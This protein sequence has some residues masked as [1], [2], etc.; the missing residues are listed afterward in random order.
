M[1]ASGPDGIPNWI[2]KDY[3]DFLA[4]PVTT[5]PNALFKEQH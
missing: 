5:I 3:S 4:N 2:L 1:K